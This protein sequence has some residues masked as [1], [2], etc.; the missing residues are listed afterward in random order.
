MS[1]RRPFHLLRNLLLAGFLLVSGNVFAITIDQAVS[2]AS[3]FGGG[4]GTLIDV[5]SVADRGGASVDNVAAALGI[6]SSGETPVTVNE[7]ARNDDVFYSSGLLNVSLYPDVFAYGTGDQLV[8]LWGYLGQGTVDVLAVSTA[9]FVALYGY[10]PGTRFG[11]WSTLDI[12]GF[13]NPESPNYQGMTSIAA[14]SISAVPLPATAPL[15][16]AGLLLLG[17]L[18]R[19]RKTHT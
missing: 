14:Y 6:S 11:G 12:A 5:W 9:G 1:T 16:L 4:L 15:F 17:V 13:L 8:G 3:G 2:Y 10:E 7:L 19:R 18:Q